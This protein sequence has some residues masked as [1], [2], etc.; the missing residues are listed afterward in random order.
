[1]SQDVP[2]APSYRQMFSARPT[3]V[4]GPPCNCY[5]PLASMVP[6]APGTRFGDFIL[7]YSP[8]PCGVFRNN[9]YECRAY[10]DSGMERGGDGTPSLFSLEASAS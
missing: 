8:L 1:M 4:R 3:I 6:K 10:V 9:G 5:H 7:V 2:V